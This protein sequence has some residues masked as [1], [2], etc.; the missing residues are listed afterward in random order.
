M[1]HNIQDLG[2]IAGANLKRLLKEQQ[3]TQ[4][5]FAEGYGVDARTVRRWVKGNL[6]DLRQLQQIA[7]YFNID[8][9]AILS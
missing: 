3:L 4:E 8:V 1:E 5:D 7:A 2:L 6:Y 9:L